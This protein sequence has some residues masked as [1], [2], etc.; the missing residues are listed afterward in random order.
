M[1]WRNDS[2]DKITRRIYTGDVN[3]RL[4]LVTETNHGTNRELSKSP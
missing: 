4:W 3:E 1:S 2:L